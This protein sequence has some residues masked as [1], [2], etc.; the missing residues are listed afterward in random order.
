MGV[1]SSRF[2]LQFGRN[3]LSAGGF[4]LGWLA[5]KGRRL[6]VVLAE[7]LTSGCKSSNSG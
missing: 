7:A 6:R 4:S 2:V 3:H 1:V 5:R